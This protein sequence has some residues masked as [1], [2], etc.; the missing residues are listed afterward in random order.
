MPNVEDFM[1][2]VVAD[3]RRRLALLADSGD[4]RAIEDGIA[5]LTDYRLSGM[6][7]R[8][9][10]QLLSTLAAGRSP[11]GLLV[12]KPETIGAELARRWRDYASGAAAR[13]AVTT[14][15]R[16]TDRTRE[17]MAVAAG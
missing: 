13:P 11:V 1:D 9:L 12:L 6:D 15:T 7:E 2:E 4:R 3:F 5:L 8:Q 14:S 10:E 16:I 17:A